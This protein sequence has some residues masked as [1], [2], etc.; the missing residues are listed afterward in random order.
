MESPASTLARRCAAL[1]D[2][3]MRVAY[4]RHALR[5]MAPEEMVALV[6]T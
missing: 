4:V 6:T 2:A 5:E 1:M 3:D